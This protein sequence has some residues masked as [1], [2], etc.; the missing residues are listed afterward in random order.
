[1][2]TVMLLTLT[3]LLTS[4]ANK[5]EGRVIA[6]SIEPERA[7]L[8]QIVGDR[9]AV[10]TLLPSGANPETFEPTIKTTR[11]VN[12]AE[13]YFSLGALPFEAKISSSLPA[14]VAQANIT[15]GI[16]PIFGTH[17]HDGEEEH[18]GHHHVSADPH[19]WTSVKNARIMAK[20]MLDELVLLDPEG[21]EYYTNRYNKLD[22]HLDSL[23]HA[24][25]ERLKKMSGKSF[26][27]WHP[28]LSYFARDY[29][30]NQ[31]SVGFENK[32]IS[33]SRMASVAEHAREHNV[34]VLFFQKEYD[35]RQ[36]STLSNELGIKVIT[37]NPLDYE[38]ERQL[39]NI[40]SELQ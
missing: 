18:E 29:G 35:S 22:A 6:V 17:D 23:D 25:A 12:D 7:L 36:V 34:R 28:S 33:P 31:I 14:S 13:A 11:E 8:E 5:H 40:V 32:E 1:M 9:F 10:K 30:L 38:W 19:T 16:A 21:K 2:M 24:F 20:N 15:R 37:I 27:V 26:A 4:C 39:D 3:V